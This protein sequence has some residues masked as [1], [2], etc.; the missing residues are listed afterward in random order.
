M[1]SALLGAA[2]SLSGGER[3]RQC[4]PGGRVK[5]NQSGKDFE[6]EVD[7]LYIVRALSTLLR[8]SVRLHIACYH[9]CRLDAEWR[10]RLCVCGDACA[11]RCGAKLVPTL[12]HNK[13]CETRL[14]VVHGPRP[15]YWI[16]KKESLFPRSK[17]KIIDIQRRAYIYTLSVYAYK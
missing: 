2:P 14:R 11:S 8:L 3:P 5:R 6:L 15:I 4:T 13:M 17:T 9:D 1:G 12:Q 16:R 10:L 7:L